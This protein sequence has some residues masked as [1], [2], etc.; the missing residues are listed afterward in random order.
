MLIPCGS[1]LV[2]P[3]GSPSVSLPVDVKE[4]FLF[5]AV[6]LRIPLPSHAS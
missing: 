5:P 3:V 6:L 4:G 2:M 1:S